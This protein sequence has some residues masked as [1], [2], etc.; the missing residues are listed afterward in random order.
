MACRAP[1]GLASLAKARSARNAAGRVKDPKAT[2][3]GVDK[4][5]NSADDGGFDKN[6]WIEQRPPHWGR[7]EN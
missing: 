2:G 4:E 3:R 1:R 5:K 7:A 6:F